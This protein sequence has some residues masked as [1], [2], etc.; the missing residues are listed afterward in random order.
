MWIADKWKD[1]I[2]ISGS[3]G[4]KLEK[5][6]KYTYLRP[7]PQIIWQIDDFCKN[8]D[9]NYVRNG[10]GG[11]W[12]FNDLSSECEQNISYGDMKF[13]IKPMGFKHMGLFPEQAVNWDFMRQKI[14]NSNREIRVLNLFAY[15][16]GATVACL[17]AGAHVCHVDASKGMIAHAKRNVELNSLSGEKVRYIVDDC[18]KFVNREARRNKKYD[19]IVMDPPSYGRGPN[20]EKW[21]V[22]VLLNKLVSSCIDVLSDKPLFFVVNTYSTG[23]ASSAVSNLLKISLIRR[24]GGKVS[25][26]EI[27]LPFLN[28]EIALPAGCTARWESL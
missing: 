17:K 24:F 10:G 16:G 15:T 2:L 14:K 13:F 23:I 27:G 5:W 22:D 6:G 9:A 7:D 28:A 4:E 18:L 26:D 3:A 21:E 12:N 1:Y 11:Y 19:A 8:A 25:A 20:G